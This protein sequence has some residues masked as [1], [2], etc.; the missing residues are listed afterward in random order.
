VPETVVFIQCCGSRDDKAGKKYCSKIC[1]MYTAKHAML[2][3]HKVHDGR[4]VIFYM[5]IR[6]AGKG[7]DEFVRR[8]VETDGA[9]YVRGRVSRIYRRNDGKLIVKG[10]DTLTGGPAVIEADLVVLADA[11][12][13]RDGSAGLA[14]LF[15]VNFDEDG[16][17]SEAHPKLRPVETSAAGVYLAGACQAPKDIPD[18]V[19]QAGACAAKVLGLFANPQ[20]EREPVIARVNRTSCVHCR[21]CIKACPYKAII[22]LDMKDREGKVV[23]VV[24]EVNEG[25]CQGCGTCAAVCRSNSIELDG[26]TD[27]QIFSEITSLE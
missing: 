3:K 26:F 2:Y 12:V 11:V 7:Y 27:E 1:C 9:E 6:A 25:L 16:F 17:Y 18:S 13:P 14:R 10:A 24:A 20:L 15:G 8:A 4:A 19:A 5:D 23:S 21:A 22:D